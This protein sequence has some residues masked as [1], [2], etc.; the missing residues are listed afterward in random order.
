M[1]L[2]LENWRKYLSESKQLLFEKQYGDW[3]VT[4]LE[5]L[6]K[7]ARSKENEQANS[8]LKKMFGWQAAQRI[9]LGIGASL[10]G[11]ELLVNYRDQLRRA[12]EGQ[13]EVSDFP[14]LAILNMDPHLIRTIEDDILNQIDEQY[15]E[16][17][18]GLNPDTK[19]RD[20][21]KINDFIKSKIAQD[22]QKHIVIRD[23]SDK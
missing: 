15:Q 22:T 6:I 2:L 5:E 14:V 16:Y 21:V 19:I 9:P 20:I 8:W 4:D 3:T 1:K 13:D 7:M 18:K 17:L 12:P 10:T 11:I 23:E